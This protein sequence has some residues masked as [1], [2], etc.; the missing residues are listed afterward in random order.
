MYEKARRRY[1]RNHNT[2]NGINDDNRAFDWDNRKV[3][4]IWVQIIMQ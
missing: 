3:R 4:L 2:D 1:V